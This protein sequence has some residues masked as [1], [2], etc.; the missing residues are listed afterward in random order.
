M[1]GFGESRNEG[2]VGEYLR[3]QPLRVVAHGMRGTEVA[4]GLDELGIARVHHP[5]AKPGES[6]VLGYRVPPVEVGRSVL[7]DQVQEGGVWWEI[8]RVI[9]PESLVCDVDLR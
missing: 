6:E 3:E 4:E 2:I 7:L 9:G 1:V 8:A 5:A